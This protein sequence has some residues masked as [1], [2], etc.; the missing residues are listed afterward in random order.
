VF[1]SGEG[2]SRLILTI[3][4]AYS[5]VFVD[6]ASVKSENIVSAEGNPNIALPI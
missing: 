4:D 6:S 3:T 1:N 2:G 5:V